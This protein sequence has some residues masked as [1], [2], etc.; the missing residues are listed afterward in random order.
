[1]Q[2]VV[3]SVILVAGALYYIIKYK[4]LESSSH[5]TALTSISATF[6]VITIC[7]LSIFIR[8][9]NDKETKVAQICTIA[10]LFGFA[11]DLA[12]DVFPSRGVI[13]AISF[14]SFLCRKIFDDRGPDSTE[15]VLSIVIVVVNW[16]SVLIVLL[17]G[18]PIHR[19]IKVPQRE[20]SEFAKIL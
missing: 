6:S 4:I 3:S 17:S 16:L 15:F 9:D 5:G 10:A 12:T 2:A 19:V 14:A 18:R 8:F 20:S 1:M 11:Y 13:A 7:G